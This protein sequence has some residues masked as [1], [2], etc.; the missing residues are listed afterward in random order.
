MDSAPA[1]IQLLYTL[2]LAR[3]RINSQVTE[4]FPITRG[5]KQGCPLPPLLFV[6]CMEPL[7]IQICSSPLIINDI[8]EQISLYAD[9]TLVYLANPH[10]SLTNLLTVIN[11]F[12]D[13][14]GF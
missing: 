14:S 7:A 10:D 5:T 13:F 12:G 8:E 4:T 9:D 2:P 6:L 3:I 1:W 11:T